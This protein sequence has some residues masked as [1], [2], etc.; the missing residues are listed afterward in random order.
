MIDEGEK[1]GWEFVFMGSDPQTFTDAGNIGVAV[2]TTA[3]YAAT[4]KGTKAV[5]QTVSSKLSGY[6]SGITGSM[7]FNADE[8]N[9]LMNPEDENNPF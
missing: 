7:A 1:L 3:A 4:A 9:Y 8:R 6:R 2:G 5:Y